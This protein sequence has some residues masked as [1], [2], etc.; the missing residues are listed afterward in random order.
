[1]AVPWDGLLKK[2]N[3]KRSENNENQARG[4]TEAKGSGRGATLLNGEVF[5]KMR[6]ETNPLGLK[7]W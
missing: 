1:M 7:T 5:D 6:I 4:V 2:A 3:A